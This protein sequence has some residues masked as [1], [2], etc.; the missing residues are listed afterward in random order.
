MAREGFTALLCALVLL[1]PLPLLSPLSADDRDGAIATTL[2]V[3]AALQQGKEHMERGNYGA[4]VHALEGQLARINGNR[5][6]LARLRD[7]YRGRVK[8]L[9]LAGQEADAQVYLRRLEILDPGARLDFGGAS[10]LAAA[11]PPPKPPEPPPAEAPPVKPAV[12]VTPTPPPAPAS[13]G[14]RL[15]YT[16][17]GK[18]EEETPAAQDDPFNPSNRLAAP[19]RT[20]ALLEQAAEEWGKRQYAAAGRLYEQAHQADPKC[21]ASCQEQWAYCKLHAVVEQ[22]RKPSAT[23]AYAEL[24]KE[25]RTAMSL[26]PRL[27]DQGKDLLDRI[28]QRRGSPAPAKA[29][30][31]SAVTVRHAERGSNGWAVAETANFRVFH[32]ETRD[33]AE[34]VARGAERTRLEVSRKWFN[35]D[36]EAWG[37]RCDLYLH[38]TAQDYSRATGKPREWSAHST[39]NSEGTRVVLRRIDLRR[40]DPDMLA[41]SLPHETTHVVLA[42]RFGG[43]DLP[44]WADEGMALLSEPREKVERYLRTLEGHRQAG[45]LFG[46]RQL[47]TMND[48]PEP[49]RAAAFYAQSV[50]LTHY[51]AELKGPQ[52]FTSFL[53]AAQR[54]GYD[55]ALQRHYGCDVAALEQ[56]WRQA[57]LGG[58]PTQAAIDGAGR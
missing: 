45:K 18:V 56:R 24:E 30:G 3:Q 42:G 26:A 31:G 8:E 36:G 13:A 58:G 1:A 38:A 39:I 49:G 29:D 52:T 27:E 41:G 43:P 32:N 19:S 25:V 7:A 22:L 50:S 48:Y 40:D 23:P 12:A 44:R 10:P 37:S 4:A 21:T 15:P 57:A 20:S 28:R 5:E 47:L 9:R 46:V 55:T 34:Q 54:Y 6:Y 33:L 11:T 17:R 53:S 35:D 16:A 51:L 2:A 14:P